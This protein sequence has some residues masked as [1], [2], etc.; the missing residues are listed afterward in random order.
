MAEK[1]SWTTGRLDGKIAVVTGAARGIGRAGAIA[2]ARA[3]ADVVGIDI[4]AEVSPIDTFAP[5]TPAELAETGEQVAASGVRW[6][7]FIADHRNITELRAISRQVE[8][9]LGRRRHRL[10]QCRY[11]GLQTLA[12]DE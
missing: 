9:G 1:K 7:Q 5:A 8:A 12:G 3:G 6:R 11:P 10:R 2:L 4:A